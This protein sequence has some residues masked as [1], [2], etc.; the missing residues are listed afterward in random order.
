MKKYI[1]I[2]P[3]VG[4]ELDSNCIK[5]GDSK[6][7]IVELLGPPCRKHNNSMY[8]FESKLRFD[9]DIKGE[10]EFI[11]FLG[12]I[13]GELQPVIYDVNAF[14]EDAEDLV[15][16]LAQK[17]NCKINDIE[18]EYSHVFTEISVGIYRDTIPANIAEMIEDARKDGVT[19][20]NEELSYQ[21]KRASH[22]ATIGIGIKGYYE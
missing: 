3:L 6:E 22:W 13:D 18:N 19:L 7:A 12:G 17:N 1:R 5:L 4:I 20:S 8:Y 21:K 9:Y 14:E 16:I 15:K 2:L 11:E 10:I